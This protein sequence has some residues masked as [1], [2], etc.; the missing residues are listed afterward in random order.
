MREHLLEQARIAPV[1]FEIFRLL[2]DPGEIVATAC[3]GVTGSWEP[4]RRPI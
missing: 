1:D 2:D 3:A 4:P